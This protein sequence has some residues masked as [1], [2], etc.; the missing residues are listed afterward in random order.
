MTQRTDQLLQNSVL[1]AELANESSRHNR[2]GQKRLTDIFCTQNFFRHATI[3]IAIAFQRSVL[4]KSL[5]IQA[6]QSGEGSILAT[7]GQPDQ[8]FFG[9]SAAMTITCWLLCRWDD[10]SLTNRL[11]R[12]GGNPHQSM[13]NHY[14]LPSS[15]QWTLNLSCCLNMVAL[16]VLYLKPT[17]D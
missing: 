8:F 14:C 13:I 3:I 5:E 17:D 10:E 4:L 7:I 6:V 12:E 15:P 11:E 2:K 16:L 1:L 9:M